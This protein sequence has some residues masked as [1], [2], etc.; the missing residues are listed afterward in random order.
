MAIDKKS[1]QTVKKLLTEYERLANKYNLN[2]SPV[3]LKQLD[4]K[5]NLGTIKPTD[6]FAK[7]RKEIPKEL[8][9]MTLEEVKRML[10]TM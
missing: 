4:E 5:R 9:N 1:L 8:E 6:L 7:L 2:I 10:K 3:K